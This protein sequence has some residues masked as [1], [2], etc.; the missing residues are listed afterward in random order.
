MQNNTETAG[1]TKLPSTA[2]SHAEAPYLQLA[3]NTQVEYAAL[4][5]HVHLSILSFLKAFANKM[6][7]VPYGRTMQA[8]AVDFTLQRQRRGLGQPLR[9]P[10]AVS[11]AVSAV[12]HAWPVTCGLTQTDMLT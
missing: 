2:E 6:S 11:A 12:S 10:V 1:P 8:K 4:H 7:S 3:R 9:W 5:T